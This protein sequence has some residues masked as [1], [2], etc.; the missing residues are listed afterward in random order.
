[1]L[2]QVCSKNEATVH[3]TELS[4]NK[5]S[6]IHLC[7]KCALEKGISVKPDFLL[8]DLLAGLVEL[9]KTTTLKEEKKCSNCGL[10][11]SDFKTTGRLGCAK[12]YQTFKSSLTALLRKIQGS[13]THTGKIPVIG[14]EEV[15]GA[16]VLKKLRAKLQ[17]LVEEEEFEEAARLRDE[18]RKFEKA[19]S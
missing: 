17:K 16:K 18:I 13:L 6:E 12:C 8:A 5:V 2:C 15:N 11:Y 1:M 10:T 4:N 9:E 3:Y 14:S 19:P 7:E